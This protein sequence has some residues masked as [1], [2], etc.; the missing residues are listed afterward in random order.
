MKNIWIKSFAAAAGLGIALN[1]GVASALP[2]KNDQIYE[3]V[4]KTFF[5]SACTKDG[6]RVDVN[7]GVHPSVMDMIRSNDSLPR[8]INEA[9]ENQWVQWNTLKEKSPGIDI[10]PP[11]KDVWK[12]LGGKIIIDEFLLQAGHARLRSDA[13]LQ[14]KSDSLQT[15]GV[16]QEYIDGVLRYAGFELIQEEVD[17][18]WQRIVSQLTAQDF[19]RPADDKPATAPS[20]GNKDGKDGVTLDMQ[21]IM[22]SAP[23]F[24]K[25]LVEASSAAAEIYEQKIEDATDGVSVMIWETDYRPPVKGC[26]VP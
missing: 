21:E 8:I 13:K 1:A 10:P 17:A 3:S 23:Y 22:D 5:T 6:Y 7:I 20:S 14:A 12:S 18:L 16:S 15:K 11:E 26:P 24:S 25:N 4:K 2:D 9:V 19:I